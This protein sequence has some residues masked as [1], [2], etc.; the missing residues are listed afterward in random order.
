MNKSLFQQ[1]IGRKY[2]AEE[3][4]EEK[5]NIK[6]PLINH[7]TRTKQQKNKSEIPESYGG[8][9]IAEENRTKGSGIVSQSMHLQGEGDTMKKKQN[10]V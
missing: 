8:I 1:F 4:R 6:Q 10:I 2:D 9:T 3:S 7:N 5:K